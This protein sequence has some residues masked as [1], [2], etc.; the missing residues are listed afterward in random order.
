VPTKPA[1]QRTSNTEIED[2]VGRRFKALNKQWQKDELER[3]CN[4]GQDHRYLEAHPLGDSDWFVSHAAGSFHFNVA[5]W[6]RIAN[7]LIRQPFDYLQLKPPCQVVRTQCAGGW[8]FKLGVEVC[9]G[10]QRHLTHKIS[11]SG[12]HGRYRQQFGCSQRHPRGHGYSPIDPGASRAI[13]RPVDIKSP[14]LN[15]NRS[16]RKRKSVCSKLLRPELADNTD[17]A[18]SRAALSGFG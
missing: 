17:F 4:D 3:V 12:G 10:Y 11:R 8:K 16:G 6:T 13:S 7:A 15:R 2:V 9:F 18:G 14:R 1:K 5:L